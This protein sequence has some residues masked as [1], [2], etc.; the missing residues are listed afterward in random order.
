MLNTTLKEVRE[1]ETELR[2]LIDAIENIK[3]RLN[4]NF[5]YCKLCDCERNIEKAIDDLT[6]I[7]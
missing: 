6:L 1:I 4:E 3:A 2:T 7:D 5:D